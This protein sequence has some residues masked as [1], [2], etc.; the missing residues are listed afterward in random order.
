MGHE[1]EAYTGEVRTTTFPG[2]SRINGTA[3]PVS[4]MAFDAATQENLF[5]RFRASDYTSGNILVDLDWY[6]DTATTGAVMWGAQIAAVTPNSDSQDIETDALATVATVT[7]THAGTVG[8]RLH[9]STITVTSLDA[10]SVED[11]VVLCVSR[12]AANAADTM[13]GDAILILVTVSA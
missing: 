13:A 12:Q 5:F 10:I 2:L 11:N 8:Q 4:G 9:R 7:T 6:A 1:F 3:I